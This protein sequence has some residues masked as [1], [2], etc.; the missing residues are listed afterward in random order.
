M[1][2]FADTAFLFVLA[3]L[4]FGPKKLPELARYL[5]K[6]MAEFRRASAE[7]RMQMDDEFRAMEQVEQQKKIAAIEAAAPVVAVALPEPEH[8]HLPA[9]MPAPEDVRPDAVDAAVEPAPE[10]HIDA[11]PS[12]AT[13]P[14]AAPQPVIIATNGDLHLKTPATGLPVSRSGGSTSLSPVFDAIPHAT[15]PVAVTT[16]AESE[17]NAHG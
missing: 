1:P 14:A 13:V 10:H 3:L 2:S 5:G 15:E 16:P 7:F 17:A 4:L 6:M 11:R 8:P 12:E 9:P